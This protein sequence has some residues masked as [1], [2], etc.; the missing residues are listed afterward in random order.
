MSTRILTQALARECF[1]YD[2]RTGA[3]TWKVR[4]LE[5]FATVRAWKIWN[6]RFSLQEAGSVN[7]LNNYRLIK[8][9]GA[10]G[11]AHR[12]I[13]LLVY[14]ESPDQIDH[15]NGIRTDNR[16]INLRAA[17]RGVN[18]K[19]QAIPSNNTS[20]HMG[21]CW[22]VRINKWGVTIK[23]D[24]K[25]RHIGYFVDKSDAIAA[26][27]AAEIEFGYHQ[28]HGRQKPIPVRD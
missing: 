7:K 25:Q 20:G 13:W 16:L 28:N 17:D 3:L 26:R 24:G 19:N 22:H 8:I 9:F 1:S 6:K 14:G 10:S 12:H 21:V 27:K 15:I 18:A 5:H 2:P 4:P 11:K 23:S